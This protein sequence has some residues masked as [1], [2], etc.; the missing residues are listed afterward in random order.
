MVSFPEACAAP[1]L[2]LLVVLSVFTIGDV[3]LRFA[4]CSIPSF[5]HG[6]VARYWTGT[7]IYASLW[8]IIGTFQLLNVATF[9]V[10]TVFLFIVAWRR[11]VIR[12]GL[13]GL[14]QVIVDYRL[15][16]IKAV[17]AVISLALFTV[18]VLSSFRFMPFPDESQYL[19][20]SPMYWATEGTWSA[21]PYR[22]SDG[23]ILWNVIHTVF[24][25]SKSNAGAHLFVLSTLPIATLTVAL[26]GQRLRV[27]QYLSVLV[28]LGTPSFVNTAYSCGTDLPAASLALFLIHIGVEMKFASEARAL[29]KVSLLAIWSLYSIKLTI[30]PSFFI[31]SLL[32]LN[33]SVSRFSDNGKLVISKL[34]A[35]RIYLVPLFVSFAMWTLRN[36]VLTGKVFDQRN[37]MLATGPN[38]WLW[39]TGAELARIPDLKELLVIPVL[40]L[41]LPFLGGQEPYGGRIGFAMLL[42]WP[43]IFAGTRL[44][45]K[46]MLF[47]ITQNLP[48]FLL[49]SS[50]VTYSLV[51][52]LVP[53][54]RYS[55]YV[56]PL[57]CISCISILSDRLLPKYRSKLML[58]S[59][60]LCLASIILD[61]LRVLISGLTGEYLR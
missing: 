29:D 39:H 56:W 51:S 22:H 31:F 32:T 49:V 33:N 21:S 17:S 20:A 38:H 16:G 34:F 10:V 61:E 37:E 40:P 7:I 54:T 14:R 8:F 60:G 9:W 30:L 42:L 2:T 18:L 47:R 6:V 12:K 11:S 19:W 28:V 26:I 36:F 4:Q 58:L 25:I 27:P 43:T 35:L 3:Y 55:A 45:L 24:A 53:K 59:A 44:N 50:W 41:I 5:V 52:I 23:P 1:I 46:G 57:M 48:A 13:G 15:R